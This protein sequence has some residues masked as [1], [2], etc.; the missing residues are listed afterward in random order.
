MT[1]ALAALL[2]INDNQF[3]RLTVVRGE[4]DKAG[5]VVVEISAL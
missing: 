3:D 2:G 4:P 1:R 5:R